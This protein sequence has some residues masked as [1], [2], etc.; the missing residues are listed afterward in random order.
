[1]MLKAHVTVTVR[2]QEM[3]FLLHYLPSLVRRQP[4]KQRT[5][6]IFLSL[7]CNFVELVQKMWRQYLR[8]E[9][10]VEEDLP[11]RLNNSLTV[12]RI[13]HFLSAH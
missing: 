3:N 8:P 7:E 1:M 2:L 12:M 13:S 11:G 10:L 6:L 5:E 9:L 4:S